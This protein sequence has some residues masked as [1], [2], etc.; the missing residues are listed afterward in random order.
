MNAYEQ[1]EAIHDQLE[2]NGASEES[3]ALVER[4]LKRAESERD[5]ATAVPQIMMVRHLLRQREALDND[6]IYND[7]QELITG[8]E[9][10]RAVRD[11]DAVRP[12]YEEEHRPR[13]KSYYKSLRQ[14]QEKN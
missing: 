3:I 7:L 11:D 5:S 8:I 1:L 14:Q 13:P 10:R 9:S 12:A 2:Q 6:A 4:F